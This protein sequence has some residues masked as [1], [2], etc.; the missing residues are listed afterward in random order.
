MPDCDTNQHI[1]ID[2]FD[3]QMKGSR[4][5]SILTKAD[6]DRIDNKWLLNF[7]DKMRSRYEKFSAYFSVSKLAPATKTQVYWKKKQTFKALDKKIVASLMQ[8]DK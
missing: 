6:L 4:N 8:K 1:N 3:T 7:F 5:F 2:L